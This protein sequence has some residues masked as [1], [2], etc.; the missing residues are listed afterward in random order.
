MEGMSFYSL[1]AVVAVMWQLE[2]SLTG[3]TEC[4]RLDKTADPN[5]R[6]TRRGTSAVP[7]FCIIHKTS[8]E[9][10]PFSAPRF[11]YPYQAHLWAI[12]AAVPEN[13]LT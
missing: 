10:P 11:I 6:K 12:I 2:I 5:A 3:D 1:L 7:H 8:P 13:N 4:C 9:F